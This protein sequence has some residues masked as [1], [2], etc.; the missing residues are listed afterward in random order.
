[1]VQPILHMGKLRSE[2]NSCQYYFMYLLSTYYLL[3]FS[4]HYLYILF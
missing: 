3:S 2:N 1:M 4:K